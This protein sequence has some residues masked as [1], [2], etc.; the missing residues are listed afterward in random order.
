MED[1]AGDLRAERN[2]H[3][4]GV[5]GEKSVGGE[6]VE[7]MSPDHSLKKLDCER[8]ERCDLEPREKEI[9]LR[10]GRSEHVYDLRQWG[11]KGGRYK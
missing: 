4:A 5:W 10:W 8:K 9:L 6:K 1:Q 7:T 11:G 2:L 3:W